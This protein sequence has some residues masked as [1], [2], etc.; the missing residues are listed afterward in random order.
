MRNLMLVARREYLEQIRGRAFRIT[1]ILVPVLFAAIFV[2]AI[3]S[4]M[5]SG[6]GKHIVIAAPSANLANAVRDE[7]LK[8]K[9]AKTVA[10][11]VAPAAPADRAQLLQKIQSKELDGMLWIGTADGSTKA[12]YTS[13]SSGDIVITSRLSA[14]LNHALALQRL[15]ARGMNRSEIDVL[16][17]DVSVETLQVDKQ[18]REVKS[19]GMIAY[20][21]GYIMALLLSMTTMIYGMNVARSIIQEK[22]SRI[23]EVMLATARPSDLL[24]GKLIGVGAVGLTQIAIWVVA[25]AAILSVVTARAMVSG[26]L[27]VHL[28][29]TEATLFIVYFLLGY[30]L[31]ASLF[32][33]LASS[34]ETEQELQMYTPL[35]ALPMWLSFSLIWLVINDPNSIWSVLASLFP[36]TAPIIMM[37]RMGSEMPPAWQFG[38]SIGLMALSV[39]LVLWVSARLYRVGILMYGKRATLPELVRWLRYS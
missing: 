29:V 19:S 5:N 27:T 17:K 22:T 31:Y 15:A 28:S 23:F 30:L 4:G 21:K 9:D 35:A 6:I 32:A 24:A 20:L 7:M 25:G 16:L 1:T 2:I 14:A 37:L 12:T 39:W 8:D 26:Q 36:A 13:Q 18:G 3:L 34:C 33:G 10:D 38:V 11:V